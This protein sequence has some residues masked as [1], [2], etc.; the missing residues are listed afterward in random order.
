MGRGRFG[1]CLLLLGLLSIAIIA[2]GAYPDEPLPD[3]TIDGVSFTPQGPVVRG[4]PLS[5]AVVIVRAGQPVTAER[6]EIPPQTFTPRPRP[7]MLV[8]VEEVLAHFGDPAAGRDS[9][10]ALDLDPMVKKAL[11][12]FGGEIVE[13][14]K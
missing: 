6:P 2:V 1:K 9:D 11:D 7:E 8:T 14:Q 3:L 10:K 5:A 12:I 13:P 4:D